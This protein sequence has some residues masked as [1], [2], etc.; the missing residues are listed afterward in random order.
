MAQP[1]TV[2]GHNKPDEYQIETPDVRALVIG[3]HTQSDEFLVRTLRRSIRVDVAP[4]PIVPHAL[5][6]GNAYDVIVL[7]RP[8][9]G[10]DGSIAICRQLR[11]G[12]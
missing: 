7:H 4:D 1:L 5:D 2:I 8:L 11:C 9:D 6:V 12:G 3:Q 10:S